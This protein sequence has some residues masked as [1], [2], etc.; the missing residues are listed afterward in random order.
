L[1][2]LLQFVSPDFSKSATFQTRDMKRLN[3][4]LLAAC[5]ALT[6]FAPGCAAMAYQTRKADREARERQAYSEYR[7]DME[8][9]NAE[10]ER[11][12]L[13]PRPILTYD[14]WISAVPY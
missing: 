12:G 6:A 9:I 3:N 11:T 14:E 2:F 13:P 4:L 7:V 1:A 8:R 5:L 10:R